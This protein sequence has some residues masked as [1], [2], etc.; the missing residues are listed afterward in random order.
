[1]HAPVRMCRV[2]F[3]RCMSTFFRTSAHLESGSALPSSAASS[4]SP[5]TSA[6][7]VDSAS[8][9]ESKTVVIECGRLAQLA[10]GAATVQTGKVE[11]L[12]TYDTP[13]CRTCPRIPS[14]PVPEAAS[15]QICNTHASQHAVTYVYCQSVRL[16]FPVRPTIVCQTRV[17]HHRC[18]VRTPL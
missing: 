16:R 6:P 11:V 13:H 9:H 4:A 7:P 14:L 15:L 2:I 12:C 3:Y 18:V 10:D 5:D 17:C 8:R 1:M